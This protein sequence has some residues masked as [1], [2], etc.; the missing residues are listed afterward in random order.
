MS[1]AGGVTTGADG[2]STG[3]GLSTAAVLAR[4]AGAGFRRTL[5]YRAAVLAGA[6]T[7]TVFGIIKLGILFAA[8]DSAGGSLGGYDRAE[9]SSY[10]WISQGLLGVVALSGGTSSRVDLRVGTGDVVVDLARPVD[11]VAAWMADDAGRALQAATFRFLA[12]MTFGALVYG[13]AVPHHPAT[14]PLFVVSVALAW[15]VSFCCRLLVEAAAFWTADVRGLE[16]VYL[17][18]SNVAAGL[19]V[20]LSVLPSPAVAVADHTPFPSMLQIPVDI[21]VEHRVGVVALTGLAVQAAWLVALLVL[22][23]WVL[24]R[25]THRVVV[26][27]G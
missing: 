2:T 14:V 9:L 11:P 10:A 7:N 17:A 3:A 5:S 13:I 27:G 22:V 25:A 20:P 24:R 6:T 4:L 26:N 8:A 23:R 12:P 18:V 21:A 1:A 16:T 15:A 19:V